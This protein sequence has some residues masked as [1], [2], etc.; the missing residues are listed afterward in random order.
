[1]AEKLAPIRLQYRPPRWKRATVCGPAVAGI[2]G[3]GAGTGGGGGGLLSSTATPMRVPTSACGVYA[4]CG[5]DDII[6]GYVL[7]DQEEEEDTEEEE[8]NEEDD[9]EEDGD[10]EDDEEEDGEE[11]S[12][13]DEGG[14]GGGGGRR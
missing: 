5:V 3:A 8:S 14:D 7:A 2:H 4:T 10:E 13:G 9:D 12:N 6:P 1:M 11:G